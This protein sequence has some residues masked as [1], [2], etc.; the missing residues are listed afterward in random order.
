MHI[1]KCLQDEIS[2]SNGYCLTCSCYTFKCKVLLSPA[3][4][5]QK[6]MIAFLARK[7]TP[8]TFLFPDLSKRAR[9]TIC[10]TAPCSYATGG[11]WKWKH[12][13]TCTTPPPRV[14]SPRQQSYII[15]NSV[16]REKLWKSNEVFQWALGLFL[17]RAEWSVSLTDW[18]RL[19]V[20]SSASLLC[21]SVN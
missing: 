8:F 13:L 6:T 20:S 4:M 15:N 3:Y 11:A 9:N 16:W 17:R 7:S 21:S 18:E 2:K 10:K 1:L 12:T 5:R 19:I 14:A